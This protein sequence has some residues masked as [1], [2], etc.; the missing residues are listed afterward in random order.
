MNTLGINRF[1]PSMIM[2]Y[3]SCP[4]KFYYTSFLGLKLP[5]SMKHLEFGNAIHSAIGNIYDQYDRDVAWKLAA[6]F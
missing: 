5:Q 2:D 1:S 6:T 4:R 3:E